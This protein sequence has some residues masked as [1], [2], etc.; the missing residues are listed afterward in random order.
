VQ[1]HD[2]TFRAI[3]GLAAGLLIAGTVIYTIVEGWSPLDA[4]YFSVVTLTTVGYGDLAPTT[5]LGKG[6][7]IVFILAGVGIIVVFASQVVNAMVADRTERV[8]ARHAAGTDTESE[9]AAGGGA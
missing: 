6:F 1:W 5:D 7:T 2:E 4:L 9:S 3:V 8:R